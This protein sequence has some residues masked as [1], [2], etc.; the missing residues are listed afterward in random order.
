[1]YGVCVCLVNLPFWPRTSDV[2]F[3]VTVMAV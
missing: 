2:T 3:V 1:M